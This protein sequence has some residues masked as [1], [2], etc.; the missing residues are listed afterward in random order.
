MTD[1]RE[2]GSWK[3]WAAATLLPSCVL[4]LFWLLVRWMP[5]PTAGG[6]A[7]LAGILVVYFFFP[8]LKLSVGRVV[9]GLL[10]ALVVAY[11]LIALS[12]RG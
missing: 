7:F 1:G 8:K 12:I 10:L 6:L 9:A 2:R 3:G 5:G 4:V 11:V